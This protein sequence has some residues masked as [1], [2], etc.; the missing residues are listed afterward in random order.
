MPKTKTQFICQKCG[1][2]SPKW[3]GK[4]NSCGEWN[5][6]VEEMVETGRSEERGRKLSS[7]SESNQPV[8]LDEIEVDESLPV[9]DPHQ[10]I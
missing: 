1:A 2:K 3:Q 4:C 9:E 7:P 8:A 6:Y 10:R 5:T